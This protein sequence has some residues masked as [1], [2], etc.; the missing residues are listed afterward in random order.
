MITNVKC[1]IQCLANSRKNT[2]TTVSYHSSRSCPTSICLNSGPDASACPRAVTGNPL[3]ATPNLRCPHG[4]EQEEPQHRILRP[5]HSD[6]RRSHLLLSRRTATC[7]CPKEL[8]PGSGASCA[9]LTLEPLLSR[10]GNAIG[11]SEGTS[12]R[13]GTVRSDIYRKFL[14]CLPADT[15]HFTGKQPPPDGEPGSP[16]APFLCGWELTGHEGTLF[17]P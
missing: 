4:L 11:S 15:I 6:R 12:P 1:L 16:I 5:S 13:D 3:Q 10:G 14:Y 17:S 7:S 9:L 2:L 8:S